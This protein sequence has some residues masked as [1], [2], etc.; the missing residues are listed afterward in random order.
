MSVLLSQCG[1]KSPTESSP[2]RFSEKQT[3]AVSRKQGWPWIEDLVLQ[4]KERGTLYLKKKKILTELNIFTSTDL[5]ECKWKQG[6]GLDFRKHVLR[7]SICCCY[8]IDLALSV[9]QMLRACSCNISLCAN[10]VIISCKVAVSRN[11]LSLGNNKGYS[12]YWHLK[13]MRTFMTKLIYF[14]HHEY[15]ALIIKPAPG[16]DMFIALWNRSFF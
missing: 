3:N 7:V 12:F 1:T 9:L 15:V 13:C 2:W 4:A 10:A 5:W 6:Q 16:I 14:S 11:K 8:C